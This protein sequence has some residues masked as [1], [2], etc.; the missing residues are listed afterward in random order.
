MVGEDVV[1]RP[2]AGLQR[3][4]SELRQVVAVVVGDVGHVADRVDAGEALDGEVG[5]GR[6]GG[7][8][9]PAAS[10]TLPTSSGAWMPPAHT[11]VRV[12]I[13]MPSLSVTLDRR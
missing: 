2:P 11:T 6:S 8:R 10:P 4:R 5:L 3:D 12:R 1:R 13:S 9:G 7:R